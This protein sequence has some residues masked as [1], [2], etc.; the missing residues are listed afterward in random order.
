MSLLN[1]APGVKHPGPGRP[2][3]RVIQVRDGSGV[4][5][6]FHPCSTAS[7]RR[8][9]LIHGNPRSLEDFD[10]L[11]PLLCPLGEVLTL[12]LPGFGQS[13][14][15][16][17]QRPSDLALPRLAEV[18]LEVAGSFGWTAPFV[19]VGHSHGGGVAQLLAARHPD[20][21]RAIVLL[22][23]LAFPTHLNYRLLPLPGVRQLMQCAAAFVRVPGFNWAKRALVRQVLTMVSSPERPSASEVAQELESMTRAPHSLVSMVDV[24]LGRPSTLLRQLAPRIQCPTL[25]I[26]GQRDAV[27]PV[28]CAEALYEGT[29]AARGNVQLH[30]LPDAGHMLAR[31]QAQRCAALI[32]DFDDDVADSA[33]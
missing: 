30:I 7:S 11:A 14:R 5:A 16:P 4:R 3:E 10:R 29:A 26:H 25:I 18:I 22:G 1:D 31:Y 32:R 20:R 2:E 19:T 23:T 8:F 13:T 12:D 21:V 6:V 24:A 15:P 33:I 9:L 17:T 28:R 27:V